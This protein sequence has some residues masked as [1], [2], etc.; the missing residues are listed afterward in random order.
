MINLLITGAARFSESQ[1][2]SFKEL[3]Y[4]VIFQQQENEPL[5]FDPAIVSAVICNNLFM[6]HNIDMFTNLKLVQLT[7]A[8]TDRFPLDKIEG[9]DIKLLN[10]VGIYSI[11][12]AE[13]IVTKVLELYKES[14]FFYQ[15]QRDGNWEKSRTI[16]ELAGQRACIVGFG[17]IGKELALRLKAFDVEVCAVKRSA[18]TVE[19]LTLVE[20]IYFSEQ[21]LNIISEVDIVIL[22]LPL[23]TSTYHMVDKVFL[24]KMKSS[25]VLVNTSRGG[26]VDEK[27]LIRCLQEGKI[28]GAALDV[29]KSEPLDSNNPLWKMDNVIISP[30]NSFVSNRNSERLLSLCLKNL[31]ENIN[32]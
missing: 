12:I 31:S 32:G 15:N 23:N 20:N 13:W 11:P 7:S 5:G 8:G 27:A 9:R 10:A 3:G 30:H 4:N 26:V 28:R 22:T 21:L 16:N 24:E 1:I 6:H 17:G 14:A 18:P 19:E 25:A 2:N 29:F